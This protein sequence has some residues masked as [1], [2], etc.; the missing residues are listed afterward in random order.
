MSKTAADVQ[1]YWQRQ[2][3]LLNELPDEVFTREPEAIHDLRA[4]GRRLKST[5][6]TF[7]PLIRK[8]LVDDLLEGLDWYN[9]VLGQARDAEVIHD[10]VMT[11]LGDRPGAGD[12]DKALGAERDR[13]A[14][15]ADHMLTSAGAERVLARVAELVDDPWRDARGG[16]GPRRRKVLRRVHWAQGRVAQ[17]WQDGPQQEETT[18]V[19]Q[20]RLRRR[21]KS[22]RY[23][24]EAV[25]HTVDGARDVAEAYAELATVLGVIQDTEVISHALRDW[26]GESAF[27][28]LA[29]QGELAGEARD[30]LVATVHRA[31]ATDLGEPA[32]TPS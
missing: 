19:W 9:S 5:V 4:A 24:A 31:L 6:R 2:L 17:V 25:R 8:P 12:I 20:H 11:L 23:A 7:R 21:A 18:A 13:T 26:P 10:T 15:I 28:A 14:T 1:E 22:A 32:A 16:R 29:A 27:E 3:A 30:K